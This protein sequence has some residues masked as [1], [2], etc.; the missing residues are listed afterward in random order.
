MTLRT[1]PQTV[2]GNT[3]FLTT[4]SNSPTPSTSKRTGHIPGIPSWTPPGRSPDSEKL[5]FT[6]NNVRAP[7]A[8]DTQTEE[9]QGQ[10]HRKKSVTSGV[11]AVCHHD[12]LL[13]PGEP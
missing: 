9:A 2:I 6:I 12:E 4:M 13:E 11:Y 10:P 5:D 8:D 3:V 7:V 1:Y